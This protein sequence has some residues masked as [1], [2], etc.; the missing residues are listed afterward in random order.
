MLGCLDLPDERDGY[1]RFNLARFIQL[2]YDHVDSHDGSD[3]A[4]GYCPGRLEA[5]PIQGSCGHFPAV[6]RSVPRGLGTHWHPGL[7]VVSTARNVHS[8]RDYDRG[9][10][11]RVYVTK[12]VLP[13]TLL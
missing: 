3:D 5:C 4:A 7:Y 1:G 6:C 12:E 8:R 11:L 2:F 10:P 9:G 13:A